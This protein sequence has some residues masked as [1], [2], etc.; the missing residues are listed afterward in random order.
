[1]LLKIIQRAFLF[2]PRLISKLFIGLFNFFFSA[3]QNTKKTFVYRSFWGRGN[4]HRQVL[5]VTFL[6]LT[7]LIIGTGLSVQISESNAVQGF[8]SNENDVIGNIDLLEQGGSIQTVLASNTG[9]S[10][11]IFTHVVDEDDSLDTLV[12]EYGVTK[13]TIKDANRDTI[14]YYEETLEVGSTLYIPEVNGVLYRSKDGDTVRWILSQVEGGDLYDVIELNSVDDADASLEDDY[15][16]LIPNAKLTEPPKPIP[17][18]QI[19]IASAPNSNVVLNAGVDVS[20]LNG[21]SFNDPLSHP[22]CAGYG[23][24]RGYTS[25]HRAVDL[26]RSGG[27]PIRTVA[28]GVVSYA[29]WG[30]GGQGYY[31]VVDH[32]GGVISQYFHGDGNIWVR[33]G[34]SVG[35]NQELMNMGCT[36][37]CTGTHLHLEIRVNG[38]AVDPAPYVP[39]ARPY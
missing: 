16:L 36:G 34:D 28:P 35:A 39:Y 33:A 10:F 23:W 18:P 12:D 27:C 30:N 4:L 32:G 15:R 29:G 22:S 2:I 38:V 24:S 21:I 13:R 20:V 6:V 26:T 8:L 3:S 17:D 9:A 19:I 31:V 25:W 14:D 37:W 11:Q 1:M 7:A 5:H